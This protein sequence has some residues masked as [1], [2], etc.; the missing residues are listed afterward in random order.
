MK[1]QFVLPFLFM[2]TLALSQQAELIIDFASGE[3]NGIS[4]Q[5]TVLGTLGNAII[6][7][8]ENEILYSDGTIQGTNVIYN[9]SNSEIVNGEIYY[10]EALFLVEYLSSD[11][12]KLIKIS[13]EG[14]VETVLE[15]GGALEL[16]VGYK[17]KLY[18][19]RR[20][21]FT[22]FLYGFDPLTGESEEIIELDWFKRSGLKDAIVFND[23]IYMIAWP[24]EASGSFLAS[25][26]GAGDVE[27]V[28]D[29]FESNVDQSSRL[30][31]NM[32][33]AETNLFFWYGDGMNDGSLY[34]S[35]GT[36]AGT[37]ILNSDFERMNRSEAARTI[38]I[39]GNKILFEGLDLNNDRHLWSSDGTVAGTFIIEQVEDIDI[40]PRYFTEFDDRLA[41]C[42]YHGSQPFS[43]PDLSTLVS[44]GTINGTTSLIGSNDFTDGPLTNG[45][46]LI[47][48]NGQLFMVGKKNSFPF[49]SDLYAF[50]STSNE[51]MKVSTIGNQA[52]NDISDLTS[53]NNNLFFFGT[54]DSLGK[55]L[56]VY[57]IVV[58][59]DGDGFTSEIDCDDNDPNVNPD[60][61]EE[62]Y[63]GIDDDCDP[64]TLDDDLDQDGF[65][66]AED[67]DD[68]NILINP[69][70]E[71]IIDNDVDEDCDGIILT[72]SIHELA[73]SIIEIYPNPIIDLINIEINGNLKFSASIYTLDGML[74]H[75]SQNEKIIQLGA[76]PNGSYFLEIQDLN[77][78]QKVLEKIM[79]GR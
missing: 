49:N 57:N 14:A 6:I 8:N 18:Y 67:C 26:D 37:Q 47:N 23:L 39:V 61:I 76:L 7:D 36:E 35:D 15:V 52:G 62:P 2:P 25:Y 9:L 78:G 48:H 17:D 46:W 73:N 33:V 40:T 65:D 4:E 44:D 5:A 55:E 58:D 59:L 53:A 63:N 45:Y 66:F 54:T 43:A 79:V 16:F 20:F 29:F 75:N 28:A 30:T 13:S 3:S 27:L 64:N 12:S 42:G 1:F 10:E 56:Y 38:G 50:D 68:D 70:A 22:E 41:F 31:I 24:E 60:Q 32:T 69:D 74:V 71:E 21:D 51:T 77:S 72:S 19:N 11:T 34:V